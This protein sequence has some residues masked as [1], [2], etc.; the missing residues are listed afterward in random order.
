MEVKKIE[1]EAVKAP[2]EM[3]KILK[4]IIDNEISSS[5]KEK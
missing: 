3:I 1:M 4:P 5:D 2:T